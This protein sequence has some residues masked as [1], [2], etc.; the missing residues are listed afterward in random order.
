MNDSAMRGKA[1][2]LKWEF[3]IARARLIA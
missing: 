2:P 3:C 1:Q